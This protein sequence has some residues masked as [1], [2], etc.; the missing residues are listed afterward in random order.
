MA[1]GSK[2]ATLGRCY[3]VMDA[4]LRGRELDRKSIAK[5]IGVEVAAADAHIK[6]LSRV[7]G[8]LDRKH[9]HQRTIKLSLDGLPAHTPRNTAVAACMGASLSQLFRGSAYEPLIAKAFEGVLGRARQQADFREASRKFLFL[10]R[11]GEIA[12]PDREG[13]LDEIVEAVLKQ[14]RVALVY[15]D[16]GGTPKRAEVSPW[17]I[18]IYDHQLYILAHSQK[19]LRAYRLSRIRSATARAKTFEY[20]D[21]ATYDPDVVFRETFGIFVREGGNVQDV[22][23]R[24][25]PRWSTYARTHRWHASQRV[26]VGADGVIVRLHVGVCPELEA[27]VLG[28]GKEAEV[29]APPDLRDRVAAQ[30]RALGAVYRG[31]RAGAR[32]SRSRRSSRASGSR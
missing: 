10:A 22:V 23:I 29:L 9:R 5:L 15:E 19:G 3:K 16:F 13:V 28:F 17:S 7:S 24:L 26:G 4:L 20:P 27:F 31:H 25:A 8:V 6:A 14:Q 1:T 11:G 2:G 18:V 32:R 21:R 30:A 12:L